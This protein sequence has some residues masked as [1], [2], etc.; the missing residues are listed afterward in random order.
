MQENDSKKTPFLFGFFLF[1]FLQHLMTSRTSCM[2]IQ[3]AFSKVFQERTGVEGYLKHSRNLLF[4]FMLSEIYIIS[5]HP[6]NKPVSSHSGQD[7]D[8]IVK[9][10]GWH[11]NGFL[12]TYINWNWLENGISS[13]RVIPVAQVCAQFWN[14][15]IVFQRQIYMLL[16]HVL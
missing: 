9:K 8:T 10:V 11:T 13:L 1:V 15:T 7:R 6:F 4:F 2:N 3:Q 5:N 14:F 16:H 12:I